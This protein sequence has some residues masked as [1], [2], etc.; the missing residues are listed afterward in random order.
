M[1]VGYDEIKQKHSILELEVKHRTTGE[2]RSDTGAWSFLHM[3]RRKRDLTLSLSFSLFLIRG[4][5][6]RALTASVTTWEVERGEG[7]EGMDADRQ[8]ERGREV[9]RE[10]K[11]MERN[12]RQGG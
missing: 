7:R 8:G 1:T 9:G 11:D 6:L 12:G 2:M 4:N 10:G 5:I 3:E